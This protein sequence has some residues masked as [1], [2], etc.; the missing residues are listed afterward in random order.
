MLH[1]ITILFFITF[2]ISLVSQNKQST[3]QEIES[4][5]NNYYDGYIY[6]D[7]YKLNLAFDTVHGTMKVPIKEDGN[8][9]GYR[10]AYFKDLIPIWGNRKK[11]TPKV[12]KNCTLTIL[13]LDIVDDLIASAKIS[14][15][16][17][18]VTYIDILSLEKINNYWK[19]TN[20]IYAVRK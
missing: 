20:K 14:M 11:L 10:N 3:L 2:S 8:I 6:R 19:I 15:K 12:L 18:K 5:I 16:V 9:T 4:T 13:N 7:I 17:D 1:K